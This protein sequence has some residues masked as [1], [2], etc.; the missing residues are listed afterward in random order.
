MIAA[1]L[2]TSLL[3]SENRKNNQLQ[4]SI[5]HTTII[6]SHLKRK[7]SEKMPLKDQLTLYNSSG[8]SKGSS[9]DFSATFG[10]SKFC[11]FFGDFRLAGRKGF[12]VV[13]FGLE[14][15]LLVEDFFLIHR[16]ITKNP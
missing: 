10:E 13:F 9:F 2:E 3:F 16:K 5:N 12:V 1:S 8:S 4:F 7:S 15:L 6:S 14:G 11:V